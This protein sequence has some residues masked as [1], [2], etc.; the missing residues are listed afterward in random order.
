MKNESGKIVIAG[1][2]GYLGRVLAGHFARQSRPVVVLSRQKRPDSGAVRYV[3]WDGETLGPWARELD[4]ADAVI[5]LAGRSVN[6][7]YN[8]RNKREI[9]ESRLRPTKAVGQGIVVCA[10]PPPVWLNASSAT[11]Y[12]HAPEAAA[13][14]ATGEPGEGFSVDVC[15]QW[16]KT[17]FEFPLP[18][19]RKVALR[20]T[21]VFGP[22]GDAFKVFR[23]LV[24]FGLGGT[25]GP[26]TQYM[27]WIHEEDFA[28]AVEFVI[29]N[30]KLKGP[31]NL[32]APNPLPNQEFMRVFRQ[33]CR[34]PV[35]L[36]AANWMLGIGAR[37]LGT[38]TELILKSRRVVPGKLNAYGFQ[39]KYP[40]WRAALENIVRPAAASKTA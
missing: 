31:V 23:R 12:R 5:N 8:E 24:N 35:G 36:P 22:A 28:R 19:T 6:C 11:I 20:I 18:R 34:R 16:E 32:A 15:Q 3:P 30:E 2:S 14:E 40:E 25:M 10:N 39:F 17:M 29:G 9:Y 21:I 37:L 26:G 38:E 27:S 4:G 7:R 13:D 1:G 33:V